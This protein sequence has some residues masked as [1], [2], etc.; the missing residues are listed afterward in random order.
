MLDICDFTIKYECFIH[1]SVLLYFYI[2]TVYSE[3]KM[4]I[5]FLT[6][7]FKFIRE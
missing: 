7:V 3:S 5:I 6:S 2:I 4:I 1:N